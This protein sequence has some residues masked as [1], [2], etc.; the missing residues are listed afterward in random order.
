MARPTSPNIG[1]SA[2]ER[3]TTAPAQFTTVE[4]GLG[5]ACPPTVADGAHGAA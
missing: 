2:G 5:G 3:A 4:S 1:A